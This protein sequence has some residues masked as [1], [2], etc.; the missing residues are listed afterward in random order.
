LA[1]YP[2]AGKRKR[3]KG[4]KEEERGEKEKERREEEKEE[5]GI[6]QALSSYSFSI[7]EDA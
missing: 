5:K 4:N 1:N 7:T 2:F 6:L 3:R